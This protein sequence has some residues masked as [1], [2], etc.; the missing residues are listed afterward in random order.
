MHIQFLQGIELDDFPELSVVA[1]LNR[2][3]CVGLAVN[4]E[5]SREK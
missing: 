1:L 3:R 5:L 4:A 2:Q